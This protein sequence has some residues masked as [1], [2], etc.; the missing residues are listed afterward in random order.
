MLAAGLTGAVSLL[1]FG[2]LQGWYP[3][4]QRSLVLEALERS[5]PFDV[6]LAAVRGSF[7]DELVLEGLVLRARPE[8]AANS[9]LNWLEELEADRIRL[10][11]DPR[12]LFEDR[13]LEV[14]SIE[15]DGISLSLAID[16]IDARVAINEAHETDPEPLQLRI[17]TVRLRELEIVA[18]WQDELGPGRLTATGNLSIRGLSWPD[19]GDAPPS[20]NADLNLR[21]G[22]LGPLAL[23]SGRFKLTGDRDLINLEFEAATARARDFGLFHASGKASVDLSNATP[24]FEALDARISFSK[25]DLAGT[26]SLRLSTSQLPHTQLSGELRAKLI[27]ATANAGPSGEAPLSIEL[28]LDPSQWGPV[29][30]TSGR[31]QLE[32]NPASRQWVLSDSEFTTQASHVTAFGSG[33]HENLNGLN[34]SASHLP[35]NLIA[36]T[37]GLAAEVSGE[38]SL[39]AALSGPLRDPVGQFFLRGDVQLHPLP[40]VNVALGIALEGNRE[41][42]IKRLELVADG[43]SKLQFVATSRPDMSE[44]FL[45]FL[46]TERGGAW[47]LSKL[48]LIGNTGE[49]EIKSARIDGDLR[50]LD[51]ELSALDLAPLSRFLGLET[52]AAG[53]VSGPFK[54]T[55]DSAR[56]RVDADLLWRKP[57]YADFAADRVHFLARARTTINAIEG[58][59][60][61][62][63][64]SPFKLTAEVPNDWRYQEDEGAESRAGAQL[65]SLASHPS[66]AVSLAVNELPASF[67]GIFLPA[68][69]ALANDE[70]PSQSILGTLTGEFNLTGS[71][72]GPAL[73]CTAGWT[74][75]RWGTASADEVLLGCETETGAL[76]LE[77]AISDQ[78]RSGFSANASLDL[79]RML[80]DPASLLRDPNSRATLQAE[81]VDLAWL[82]P[83]ASARRLGR[84]KRVSGKASG[85]LVLV[86][87]AGGPLLTGN[88]EVDNALVQ[89]ALVDEQIGPIHAELA[90]SNEEIRIERIE[91]DSSKGSATAS[92]RYSWNT[93]E[94]GALQ[95]DVEFKKF[96][97]THFPYLDARVRGSLELAGSLNALRATGDLVFNRVRVTLPAP[98]DPL[99]REV[100]ILGL[101]DGEIDASKSTD[102]PSAYQSMRADIAIDVRPGARIVERG[103]DLEAEGQFRLRKKPLSPA[104]LQGNLQTTGGTYTFLGR[105]FDVDEGVALF[106]ERTPPDPELRLVATR[107]SG[108]VTVG[109]EVT[110]RWSDLQSRL[111]SVPE[112]DDTE[113]LSYLVFDKPPTEIGS[114]ND[115][116]LSA[117]AAQLA[118]NLAL[119]EFSRVLAKDFP[120]N[121]ISMDVNEDMSVA[122]VGVETNVGDDIVLR[123]DR[124]LQRGTGDR[125]S[126]EWRF[127]KNLSLRSEYENGGT[128]G[129]DLFWS[130][131][132]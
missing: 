68:D 52:A 64:T 90:F 91:I 125:F 17:G 130:Y 7:V 79:A 60:E 23:N 69:E 35:I 97:L 9:P 65:A 116:E 15:V 41:Y 21:E 1:F 73:S 75:A 88:L 114:G 78:A 126:V 38:L 26:G 62:G 22:V 53:T 5:L 110:G 8:Q 92:G 32:Y 129:L 2:T 40:S 85:E 128:S 30:I 44:P 45:R 102:A 43:P 70:H 39:G 3:P 37:L 36:T 50:A 104:L 54:L 46:E 121:A 108:D 13:L 100:R 61:W 72:E 63:S 112:M 127:W 111:I 20:I 49:L 28:S 66:F 132:Y 58:S 101:R 117:A 67:L 27:E 86:G 31:A 19:A 80:E 29:E 24:S 12:R 95:L 99:F 96:A 124:A 11:I 55:L 118:G 4:L 34:L 42:R 122:S 6:E 57:R 81:S 83:R 120:I 107:T 131:E 103:A 47:E 48:N 82:I 51:L 113:I 56:T 59:V 89:L 10:S 14:R 25:L 123:Y 74:G 93:K 84:I 16:R 18:R 33:T 106:E 115:A 109:V 94:P 105:R 76:Q 77:L 119:S 87:S 71:S 98:D